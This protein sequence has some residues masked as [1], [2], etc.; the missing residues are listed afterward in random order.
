MQAAPI[1]PKTAH[2]RRRPNL[3]VPVRRGWL[4]PPHDLIGD[5]DQ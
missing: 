3:Q 5:V 4:T 2:R 1:E